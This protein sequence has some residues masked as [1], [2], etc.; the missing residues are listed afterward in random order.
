MKLGVLLNSISTTT[1]SVLIGPATFS[2]WGVLMPTKVLMDMMVVP[3][4]SSFC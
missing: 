2:V 4:T 3:Y 1:H